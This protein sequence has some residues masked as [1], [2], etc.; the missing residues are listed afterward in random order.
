MTVFGDSS[1]AADHVVVFGDKVNN[2]KSNTF[3]FNGQDTEFV[4]EQESAFYANSKVAINGDLANAT[5]DVHGGMMIGK[6]GDYSVPR[7]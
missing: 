1:V 7:D 3:V 4:P 5:L 6:R 2:N